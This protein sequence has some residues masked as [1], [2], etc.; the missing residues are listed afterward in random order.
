MSWRWNRC[1]TNASSTNGQDE[2][3]AVENF[4]SNR[5]TEHV[6]RNQRNGGRLST[7]ACLFLDVGNT[8]ESPGIH[9]PR[10]NRDCN[11][12]LKKEQFSWFVCSLFGESCSYATCTC[13]NPFPVECYL[14]AV[15]FQQNRTHLNS[16][17]LIQLLELNRTV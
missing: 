3:K 6:E 11:N 1:S 8:T 5:G 17:E 10:C 15:C 16:I 9:I 13:I 7:R 14:T 2:G 12:N 4:E